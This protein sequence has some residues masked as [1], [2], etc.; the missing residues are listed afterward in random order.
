MFRLQFSIAHAK[1]MKPKNLIA[2]TTDIHTNTA[3][4]EHWIRMKL[5]ATLHIRSHK[6]AF[7]WVNARR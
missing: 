5:L 3:Y 1:I 6:E 2:Q 7:S 4:I